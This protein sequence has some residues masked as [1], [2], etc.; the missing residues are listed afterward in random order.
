MM[1]ALWTK[2]KP[3][4]VGPALVRSIDRNQQAA[5]RLDAALREVLQK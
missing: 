5:D 1:I 2:L 4:L 3:L